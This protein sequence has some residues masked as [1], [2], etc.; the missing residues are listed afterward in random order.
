MLR[1]HLSMVLM[2]PALAFNKVVGD[3]GW[4]EAL[5]VLLSLKRQ[6]IDLVVA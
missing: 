5:T 6:R 1:D 2:F 3:L 4:N